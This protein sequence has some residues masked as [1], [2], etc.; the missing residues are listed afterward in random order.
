V[1]EGGKWLRKKNIYLPVM[2]H[3]TKLFFHS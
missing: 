2:N 1:D 3:Q